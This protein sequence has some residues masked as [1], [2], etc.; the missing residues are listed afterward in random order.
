MPLT[1]FEDGTT[2][3]ASEVNSN[4]SLCVLTDTAKTITVT[5]TWSAS[6]TL[7]GGLTGGSS[8]N[9][10]I[11]TNKFTVAASTGNTAVGGTLGVTG[12]ATL[13]STLAVTG[14]VSLSS[15]L[16][17]TS[18][19][20]TQKVEAG[21]DWQFGWTGRSRIMSDSDGAVK[22]RNNAD[23]ANANITA[24]NVTASGT[25]GVTGAAT[26]SSTLA[27][28]GAI[29]ATGGV[30]GNLTGNASGSSGSCTGLAATATALATARNINGVAFDGTA[31]ITVTAEPDAH[32][33]THAQGGTDAL[34]GTFAITVTGNAGTATQLQT[35]RTINGTSFDGT[36]NITVTAAA[37]TLTGTT[38]NSTVVTSSLT[39]VGTLTDLTVTNTITGSVSGNAGTAT[40][41]QTARTIG[42]TSFDGTAN[43]AV[44][45]ASTATALATARNINGVAFDGTANITV[46]AAAGTLTGATLAANVLASSLTSVGTLTGLSMGGKLN[47]VAAS[48]G[49]AG[50]NLGQGVQPE[51]GNLVVG[52]LW[53]A[54]DGVYV[55]LSI[56]GTPQVF[57]LNMTGQ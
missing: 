50:L 33:S 17:A 2:A 53:I 5:H 40:A 28:T 15:T 6:Q 20:T 38:L 51:L 10:T 7:N 43:I 31:N 30:V 24:G 54:T 13:S 36:A 11:N 21:A 56:A 34:S 39:S 35:A 45:L 22:F 27:V 29:T 37:G 23:S 16:T 1:T 41:L 42:G 52:D 57:K 48:A 25:L 44:A 46:T 12:A 55:Y 14:A 26:L 18:L 4:F 19:V 9:I 47:C 49:R 3:L 8:A 32:A